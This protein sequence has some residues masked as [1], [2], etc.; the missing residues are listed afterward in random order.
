[1][2][3]KLFLEK[4]YQLREN[5]Q[6]VIDYRKEK[7]SI[8][9][10]PDSPDAG[11]TVN[12]I[13][14]H[15]GIP[16]AY[17]VFYGSLNKQGFYLAELFDLKYGEENKYDM[18]FY[19]FHTDFFNQTIDV[20]KLQLAENSMDKLDVMLK[21]T[22]TLLGEDQPLDKELAID[23]LGILN[24][25]FNTKLLSVGYRSTEDDVYIVPTND[26]IHMDENMLLGITTSDRYID[27][28]M[29]QRVVNRLTHSISDENASYLITQSG[30]IE[31]L[32]IEKQNRKTI[33]VAEPSSKEFDSEDTKKDRHGLDGQ[34][35]EFHELNLFTNDSIIGW[36]V[37]TNL[38]ASSALTV[39]H[40]YL[41]Y[42]INDNLYHLLNKKNYQFFER[43]ET[44][45]DSAEKFEEYFANKDWYFVIEDG[46][47]FQ[48]E[49]V[50]VRDDQFGHLVGLRYT[51]NGSVSP[52]KDLYQDLINKKLDFHRTLV[53][54]S[55]GTVKKISMMRDFLA[56]LNQ[57]YIFLNDLNEFKSD[58]K[59]SKG[60]FRHKKNLFQ[61]FRLIENKELRWITNMG[62][63]N[64]KS[65]ELLMLNHKQV[66]AMLTKDQE[67]PLRIIALNGEITNA[68]DK[69]LRAMDYIDRHEWQLKDQQQVAII[70]EDLLKQKVNETQ[71][72]QE[73]ILQHQIELN[74]TDIHGDDP[75][76]L[77]TE[78]LRSARE[79]GITKQEITH[80]NQLVNWAKDK[81]IF[82][83]NQQ[84]KNVEDT[85][86]KK[87]GDKRMM[88]PEV[89]SKLASSSP[90]VRRSV[91]ARNDLTEEAIDRLAND[92]DVSVRALTATYKY[93]LDKLVHDSE[94]RVIMEVLQ[95][96]YGLDVIEQNFK[97]TE[98]EKE[99]AKQQME[100]TPNLPS[101]EKLRVNANLVSDVGYHLEQQYQEDIPFVLVA[102]AGQGYKLD[103]LAQHENPMVSSFAKYHQNDLQRSLTGTGTKEEKLELIAKGKYRAYF[104]NDEDPDIRKALITSKAGYTAGYALDVLSQD[105]DPSVA[106]LAKEKI[107][108]NQM[109]LLP[110]NQIQNLE[111]EKE[112]NQEPYYSV[113]PA[114]E[115]VEVTPMIDS[116]IQ[117]LVDNH[118]LQQWKKNSDL[119][120]VKG[121]KKVAI[122]RQ[123][124]GSFKVSEKFTP[125][126]DKAKQHVEE[127]LSKQTG[128]M[129]EIKEP[130]K[131]F[132]PLDKE[133]ISQYALDLIKNYVA[134]PQEMKDYLDFMSK[135]PNLSPRN[136]A[137]IQKQWHGA[138]AVATYNQWAEYH[139]KLGLTA[140]DIEPSTRV[141]KNRKTGE[142][143][144]YTEA[145]LSVKAGEKAEITLFRPIFSDV[146]P[147]LD[148]KGNIKVDS[149]GSPILKLKEYAT[150]MEKQALKE[151]KIKVVGQRKTGFTT[152]K[153]FE[154]SQTNLKPESYPKAMP[155]R[156]YNFDVDEEVAKKMIEGLKDYSN[157]IGVP[158]K[159][160]TANN[161]GNAHGAYYP[162]LEMILLNKN[163]TPTEN[164][165]TSIH[166][167]AHAT[168]HNNKKV[169]ASV[170]EFEAEMTSYIVAKSFGMDTGDK[171]VHYIAGWTK[172]LSLMDDKQLNESLSRIHKTAQK[173]IDT[174]NKRMDPPINKAK[175]KVNNQQQNMNQP[176]SFMSNS[177]RSI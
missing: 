58:V 81:S 71:T 148:E 20:E 16:N 139:E 21:F 84:Q 175:E 110:E 79:S 135:F 162:T 144:T 1:M 89:K 105:A 41:N 67:N 82:L 164:I 156:H 57:K 121:L 161:L 124:D 140:D 116:G 27:K 28:N 159:I 142:E 14:L 176:L 158:I 97:L 129:Q 77:V 94:D 18:N 31:T 104:L 100:V 43:L 115:A 102:L 66:I 149:K 103:E 2:D 10:N 76:G 80:V 126:D 55:G 6:K 63:R 68:S 143:K 109:Y 123:E 163:N 85:W 12:A 46:E 150:E 98:A 22:D 101:I 30:A 168:L 23:A 128:Q 155:N 61:G 108:E 49:Q 35:D 3:K 19:Q 34:Q 78:F 91:L 173:M 88:N 86:S 70:M 48:I 51:D 59:L 62:F 120:F 36:K 47:S 177:A 50:H 54:E 112:Q 37:P 96:M 130:E 92:W 145:K 29:N 138:N 64:K 42:S 9:I 151:G 95:H 165:G 125:T 60:V 15:T 152:Y 122:E 8:D 38:G 26:L 90:L 33:K 111:L 69:V 146:I 39:P 132:N 157:E 7:S 72:V 25:N 75:S 114:M 99:V 137:L 169:E 166:E 93:R 65:K 24:S 117:A 153:V 73:L 141:Y 74:L 45:Y 53:Q 131:D 56:D 5:I 134:D 44:L 11:F 17:D 4:L 127:I 32:W 113:A 107:I 174:I 167:L 40:Q 170:A 133:N 136:V 154:L 160:D 118:E 52:Q 171:A 106:K 147:S 87:R 13:Y 83:A 172:N 119:Y